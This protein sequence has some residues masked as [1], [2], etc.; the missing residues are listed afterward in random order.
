M[1]HKS[2]KGGCDKCKKPEQGTRKYEVESDEES[3]IKVLPGCG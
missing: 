1:S 2:K 3:Q